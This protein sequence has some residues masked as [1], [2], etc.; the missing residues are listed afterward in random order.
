[1]TGISAVLSLTTIYMSY[2]LVVRLLP[3]NMGLIFLM[4]ERT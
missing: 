1:V 3:G 2:S 4:R